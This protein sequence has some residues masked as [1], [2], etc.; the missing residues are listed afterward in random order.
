MVTKGLLVSLEVKAGNDAVA[1]DVLRSALP[2]VRSEAAT[3]A[4]FAIR[5]GRSEYGIFDVFPDDTGR[6][7]HMTGAV[8]HALADA[9]DSVFA[10]APRIQRTCWPTSY[11]QYHPADGSRR[12]CSSRSRQ[13]RAMS[14]RS[15][16][17]FATRKH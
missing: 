7:T 3:T 16:S 13:R 12:R 14:R 15:S 2:M 1:E 11:R 5:F 6:E 17:F 10:G 8:A 4:W 9:G